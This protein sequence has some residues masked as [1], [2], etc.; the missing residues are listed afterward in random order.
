MG[1]RQATEVTGSLHFR[2][3]PT[4]LFKSSS[5]V[6]GTVPEELPSSWAAGGFF[7]N[8]KA[9][10]LVEDAIRLRAGRQ[11]MGGLSM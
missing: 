7:Q 8:G 6:P 11:E 2:D 3:K 4:S 9:D 10:L 5:A 1:C